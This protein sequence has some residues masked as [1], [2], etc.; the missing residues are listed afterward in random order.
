MPDDRR[1]GIVWMNESA[2][3]AIYDLQ[4]AFTSALVRTTRDANEVGVLKRIDTLLARYGGQAAHGRSDQFSHAF[5]NH[6]LDMLRSMSLTLPPVFFGIAFFLVHLTLGRIVLL[7]RGQIGLLKAFGYGNATVVGHYVK[8]VAIICLAGFL[9]GSAAG[10]LLGQYVTRLYADYFR[11]PLLVFAPSADIYFLAALLPTLAGM[12]GAIQAVSRVV[13]LSPAVAMRPLAPPRYHGSESGL[14]RLA[15]A[16]SPLTRMAFRSAV[17]NRLRSFMTMIGLAMSLAI[18]IASLYLADSMEHLVE[19]KYMLS[20]RQDATIDFVKPQP[21]AVIGLAKRMPGVQ[22]AEPTRMVPARIRNGATERRVTLYGRPADAKLNRIVDRSLRRVMPPERGIAINSWLARTLG[23]GIGD[24]VE[25]DMLG[26]TRR[27]VSLPVTILTEDYIGLQATMEISALSRLL[28]EAPRV[29]R[30]ELRIDPA[31][32]DALYDE[33]KATPAFGGIAL[34]A[35]SLANFQAALVIIVTAMA[36]IYTGLAGTIAFG[37]VYNAVRISLSERTNELATL[38]V[39]GFGQ[40]RFSGSWLAS[41]S[42]CSCSRSHSD[43]LLDM[44]SRGS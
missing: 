32:L 39:L 34:Q 41:S 8:F 7:E 38:R 23:V 6:G 24:N 33:V 40:G 13:A 9:A 1:F 5:L 42:F 21:L 18:L 28:H 22:A 36:S 37:M 4:G 27:T 10:I 30:T 29:D 17:H 25:I 14:A 26:Q 3:A 31:R 16:L 12:T 15:A 35:I 11:F 20:E 43:G 2:L 44:G 19:V